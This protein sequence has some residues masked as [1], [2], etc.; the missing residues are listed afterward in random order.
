MHT[1]GTEGSTEVGTE[2]VYAS[3]NQYVSNFLILLP[4][5]LKQYKMVGII[6]PWSLTVKSECFSFLF[7]SLPLSLH[8]K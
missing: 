3:R 2:K 7:Y 8:G 4:N 5:S 1:N 6:L